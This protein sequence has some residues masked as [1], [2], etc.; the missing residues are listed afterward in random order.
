M[1]ACERQPQTTSPHMPSRCPHGATLLPCA[2]ARCYCGATMPHDT[3]IT[4]KVASAVNVPPHAQSSHSGEGTA[5]ALLDQDEVL[6]DDFQT[7][8]TPV[9]HVKWRGDSGGGASA[10]E[11]LNAPEEAWGSRPYTTWTSAKKRRLMKQLTPCGRQHAGCSW[12]SR[13][14]RTMKGPGMSASPH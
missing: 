6:E 11:G 10:G 4:P 3:P 13:A 1:P 8:H 7:Q 12:R 14:F 5:L 2:T 9:R